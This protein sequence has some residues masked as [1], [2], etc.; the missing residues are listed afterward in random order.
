MN[1]NLEEDVLLHEEQA[2]LIKKQKQIIDNLTVQIAEYRQI[3]QELSQSLKDR[4]Q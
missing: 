1:K 2:I 4:A 3:V